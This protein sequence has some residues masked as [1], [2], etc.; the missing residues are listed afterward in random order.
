MIMWGKLV[1]LFNISLLKKLYVSAL[2][3][4]LGTTAEGGPQSE[5]LQEVELAVVDD[6]TCSQAM[7]GGGR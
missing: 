2:V 1:K 5:V 4:G 6:Q 7:A 3:I